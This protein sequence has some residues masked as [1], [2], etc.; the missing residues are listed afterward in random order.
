MTYLSNSKI[1]CLL[2]IIAVLTSCRKDSDSFVQSEIIPEPIERQ[3][4]N[5]DGII[6][7]ETGLAVENAIVWLHNSS[8]ETDDNGYFN[9]EGDGNVNGTYLKIQ[10]EGYFDGYGVITPSKSG[11]A[12]AKFVLQEKVLT[13]SFNSNENQSIKISGNNNSVML[14]ADGYENE[15]G[16]PY[17]G[18]VN[19]YA[20]YVDP[21]AEN[22]S[23]I[24]PGDL[25]AI[26]ESQELSELRSFGMLHIELYDD[27]QNPLQINKAATII[28]DIPSSI[29]SDAPDQIP[30]WYFDVD[31]GFWVEEG[32]AI[33]IGDYYEGQVSHFSLW[34]CDVPFDFINYTGNIT[35]NNSGGRKSASYTSNV[36]IKMTWIDNGESVCTYT[37][38]LGQFSGKVPA[39]EELLMEIID[40]CGEVIL[41]KNIGPF[42]S[43]VSETHEVNVNQDVITV[44][45]IIVDC[46]GNPVDNGYVILNSDSERIII[47]TDESGVFERSLSRCD[48][49]NFSIIAVDLN[50]NMEGREIS[51]PIENTTLNFG[52]IIACGTEIES[53]VSFTW[54]EMDFNLPC[55]VTYTQLEGVRDSIGESIP[56]QWQFT[57]V[58]DYE[59]GK[60]VY[61]FTFIDWMPES[62]DPRNQLLGYSFEIE[63][64]VNP[65]EEPS[66]NFIFDGNLEKVAA[67]KKPGEYVEFRFG[68][69]GQ[70]VNWVS[71]IVSESTILF[72][73]I[74]Q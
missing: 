33:K 45:G 31:T 52:N 68:G 8:V 73:G 29:L 48:R 5:F 40:N 1:L 64:F 74:I 14:S 9:I 25:V 13:A 61:T 18:N 47:T 6:V 19:V 7:D 65:G 16:T 3:E 56:D 67:G 43:D 37:D 15:N 46:D 39:N 26:S 35:T 55:D 28:V 17:T 36:K 42:I 50:N 10:K 23:S 71:D 49:D 4:V 58:D 38:N 2:L 44:T 30:L 51:L 70:V 20:T 32:E 54:N 22:F 69:P 27:Q 11:T 59:N 66:R 62:T 72:R 24:M 53:F 41:S 57:F 60:S 34:N 12:H 63:D 21:T